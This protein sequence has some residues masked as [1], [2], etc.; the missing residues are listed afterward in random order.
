MTAY[1]RVTFGAW[2]ERSREVGGHRGEV[3]AVSPS[4]L[5]EHE[6]AEW[7]GA[8]SLPLWLIDPEWNAF[9]DRSNR[10]AVEAGLQLR[11]DPGHDSCSSGR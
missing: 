5:T 3:V 9:L 6:V 10:A 11:P 4:W 7:S 1:E 2:L 8:E